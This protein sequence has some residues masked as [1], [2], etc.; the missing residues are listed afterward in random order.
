MF[1]LFVNKKVI[2]G[3]NA[4]KAR[5]NKVIA[6]GTT[7]LRT[8]ESI[9]EDVWNNPSDFEAD[10]SF[11]IIGNFDVVHC[12]YGSTN[13]FGISFVRVLYNF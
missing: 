7:S 1:L 10:S 8:L 11:C 3:I 6:V 5:G 4:E 9:P 12:F 13:S 2:Q